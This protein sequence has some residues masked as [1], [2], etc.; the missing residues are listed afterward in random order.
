MFLQK[1]HYNNIKFLL[2]KKKNLLIQQRLNRLLNKR[3]MLKPIKF[4]K[5]RTNPWV[6]EPQLP[7]QYRYEEEKNTH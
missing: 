4:I 3:K 6:F 1:K 7:I 2:I 5:Q